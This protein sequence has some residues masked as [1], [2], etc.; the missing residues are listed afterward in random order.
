MMDE[1]QMDKEE[2]REKLQETAKHVEARVLDDGTDPQYV[3][4]QALKYLKRGDEDE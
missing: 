4:D 2:V 1:P 3:I